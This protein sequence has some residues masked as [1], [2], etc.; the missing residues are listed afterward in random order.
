MDTK[1]KTLHDYQQK[2]T[3][4]EGRIKELTDMSR[5]AS[6]YQENAA[7]Y[8]KDIQGYRE[9][10]THTQEQLKAAE[11][12]RDE[13]DE[14]V[15]KRTTEVESM[16][17]QLQDI[18]ERN[19]ELAQLV[20]SIGTEK[21]L[22]ESRVEQMERDGGE[23]HEEEVA[24]LLQQ[25]EAARHSLSKAQQDYDT[26]LRY[27]RMEQTK[28][29]R[30]LQ[31]KTKTELE[32]K[33][34]QV[35]RLTAQITQASETEQ[36]L[37]ERLREMHVAEANYTDQIKQ[38]QKTVETYAGLF[39]EKCPELL[40]DLG[41]KFQ[42][43]ICQEWLEIGGSYELPC[44]D[45]F[46]KNCLATAIRTSVL[47]S[48]EFDKLRCPSCY[49][50]TIR[51][52]ME[53]F[54]GMFVEILGPQDADK[55]QNIAT[56]CS[57]PIVSCPIAGCGEV[58]CRESGSDN[59]NLMCLK[60]H[61]FCA[62]CD[63]GPHPGKT[64][65]ERL[66]ELYE[67]NNQ[68]AKNEVELKREL[69]RK[70]WRPCPRAGCTYGGG[71]K[72]AGECDHVTCKCG[73]E[74]CWE[75]G[76]NRKIPFAHDNRWHKPSCRY[77]T[78]EVSSIH[79]PQYSPHCPA[80]VEKGSVC[81]FPQDDGWPHCEFPPLSQPPPI[82]S[83]PHGSPPS[84]SFAAGN[85]STRNTGGTSVPRANLPAPP[86]PQ[87]PVPPRPQQPPPR[88]SSKAPGP[89]AHSRQANQERARGPTQ[90]PPY[91]SPPASSGNLRGG[92]A[93]G[94]PLPYDADF[95]ALPSRP[96]DSS[97]ANAATSSSSSSPPDCGGDAGRR[98]YRTC[99]CT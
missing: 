73:F 30:D 72:D 9:Q 52:E 77:H 70:G 13:L 94:D 33:D 26:Q 20:E 69:M 17:G 18:R 14:Q 35:Q 43:P 99:N 58:V 29:M 66:T 50:R 21:A 63:H 45:R 27:V 89:P 67:Q 62:D 75:C 37:R 48:R 64:C 44:Q 32:T 61:R 93:P 38:L 96:A 22:L 23:R 92:L 6:I 16:K 28:D 42:C 91:G 87:A 8:Y 47:E 5:M 51:L 78:K 1:Q 95:P 65:R 2:L 79:A 83:R 19:D 68:N 46:C 88:P 80:C 90:T 10:L 49:D 71:Y 25:V 74:F 57:V 3:H 82:P 53:R 85:T 86:G 76:V 36:K 11:S 41:G 31:E 12:R 40:Q 59:A 34:Q 15:K 98:G 84:T 39:G 24:R 54:M 97:A 60:G 4:C 7:K 81:D 55:L 56:M